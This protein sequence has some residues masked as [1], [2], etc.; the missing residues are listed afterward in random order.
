MENDQATLPGLECR[1]GRRESSLRSEQKPGNSGE[2]KARLKAVDRQQLQWRVLDVE[3]LIPEDH[4]ARA[5]WDFVGRLDLS[6]YEQQIHSVEGDAGRPALSPQL[7]ISL[8]IYAYSQGVSSARA[9]GRLCEYDPAYQWLT[10]TE[11]ISGHTLSD[12]RVGHE[13]ALK[14]MFVQVLAVLSG[15]GLITLERVAQDGTKIKAS[16]ACDSFRTDEG[17]QQR[18]RAAQEHIEAIEKM[19]E[20]E[21][22]QRMA[23]AQE[24]ARREQK[25]RLEAAQRE[26]EKLRAEGNG[27]DKTKMRVSTTDADARVMKQPDGGFAPSYNVQLSTDAANGIIVGV[28]VTQAGNDF[29]QLTPA[30][31][32]VE[33]NLG[34]QPKQAMA[35]GGYVSRENIIDTNARGVEFIGPQGEQEEKGAKSYERRGVHP[36]YHASQFIYDSESDSFRCPQ[37]KILNYEGKEE[38]ASEISKKYRAKRADCQS[39]PA[40]QYCCPGN[41]ATGRSVQRSEELPEVAEFRQKMATESY[42]EIYRTRPQIAETPNLWIKAKFGLRQFSVRGLRKVEMEALWAALTYNIRQWIRLMWRKTEGAA[43]TA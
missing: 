30:L 35:D 2:R 4:V 28:G 14:R 41:R 36:E 9:I 8:W 19:A 17:I 7:L 32:R 13:D 23:K 34:K 24:R 26:F 16:T 33:E 20:E 25:E 6:E 15:D 39:C 38:R 18:L 10:G 42:R 5:I 43:A 29:Q 22:S 40:K 3:R 12:F 21:C 27:K 31:D 1:D 37:G 11:S